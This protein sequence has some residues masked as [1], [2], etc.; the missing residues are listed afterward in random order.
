MMHAADTTIVLATSNL[1]KVAE[2][3][4]LLRHLP[5]HVVSVADVLGKMP[6]VIEDGDSFEANAV[7]KAKAIA[8]EALMIAMADDS[9][10]KSVV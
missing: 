6:R 10:R 9:D 4:A 8:D 1:G 7:K 2:F 3:R 5:V